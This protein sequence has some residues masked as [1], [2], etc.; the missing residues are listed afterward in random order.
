MIFYL[1][2]TL[3]MNKHSQGYNEGC[4]I[5]GGSEFLDVSACFMDLRAEG[6]FTKADMKKL[7]VCVSP[8]T[9]VLP[10]VDPN[11]KQKLNLKIRLCK[12]TYAKL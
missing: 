5:G 11:K 9:D 12:G 6:L 8:H 2:C 10:V 4:I 3:N 1:H 7:K